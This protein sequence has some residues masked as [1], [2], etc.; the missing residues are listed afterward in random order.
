MILGYSIAQKRHGQ[1][2][3]LFLDPLSMSVFALCYK[4]V[5]RLRCRS[6]HQLVLRLIFFDLL[7]MSVL[8]MCAS[9]ICHAA[10]NL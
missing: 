10:L 8:R 9:Q 3:R 5:N 2:I 1:R 4:P 6:R 7:S